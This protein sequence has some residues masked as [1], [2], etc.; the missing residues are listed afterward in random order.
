MR[1]PAV[2]FF[3]KIGLARSAA[4]S[5]VATVASNK[6]GRIFSSLDAA[7]T[8]KADRSQWLLMPP[9]DKFRIALIQTSCALDPNQNLAKTEWKIREA[10]AGGAQIVCLQELFRSQYFCREENH[11]LFALAENPFTMAKRRCLY[12]LLRRY[13]RH[14]PKETQAAARC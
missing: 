3:G 9:A 5:S 4:G 10:A 12:F 14:D 1:P 8:V 6:R 11:D 13:R 2:A 7:R